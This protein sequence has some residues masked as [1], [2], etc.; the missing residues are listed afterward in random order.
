MSVS[1]EVKAILKKADAVCFDVDSTVIR[2]EGIDELAKFFQKGE[3]VSK[4]TAKAMGGG[5]TFQESLETRLNI[6]QPSVNQLKAFIQMNPP[7]LSPGVKNLVDILHSYKV[8]VYLISGGFR[9]IIQ[10]IAA[11]L[12][13]PPA[14]VY[15]N[16]LLFYFTG[17]YAGFDGTCPTCASG[18]KAVV[19]N[20]LKEQHGYKNVVL[21]GDGA[22]DLEAC[23]PADAFIGYGGNVVRENIRMRSKW[24]V[25]DFNEIIS[26]LKV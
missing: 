9:C 2:E 22:T 25:T 24:Y 23:P 5:M 20:E 8:P 13:I 4:L 19:I 14:N 6:L 11:E 15:C 10:P 1:D 12:G 3:E 26:V 7:T 16:Q 17:E 18:G 21:I